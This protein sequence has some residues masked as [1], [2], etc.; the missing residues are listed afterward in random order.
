VRDDVVLIH[1]P[2]VFDFRERRVRYG[3]ISDV[4]PSS[5][6]FEMYPVGFLTMAAYLRRHGFRVRI[7]NL[8]LLMMR[9]RRFRPEKLLRKLKP[10]LFGI[11]LHWLPHAHGATELAALLKRLHPEIPIVFGGIS[12]S[13]FHEELIRDSAADFVLRGSVTEPTLLAL[14]R[15]VESGRAFE[16][17]PGLT[18][19]SEGRTRVNPP[20]TVP[21]S[22]DEFTFN[23]GSMI[24][25]V[26]S[27]LDFWTSIPFHSYWR[28]PI[29]A[30]FTVRGCRRNCV[31]CGA[32]SSSF[33]RFMPGQ[34]PLYRSPEAIAS[35]V[36][37]LAEIARAPIFLVGDIRDGG[38]SYASEVLD[39]LA[40]A[41]VESD[42]LR[43]L[44]SAIGGVSAAH[45]TIGS[46]VGRRAF[47]GEPRPRRPRP[48]R[49]GPVYE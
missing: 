8:A 47:P 21:Q 11:D 31:S 35:M 10:K 28:H 29:T 6:V 20:S 30:V 41:S 46:T 32:S 16:T 3:P 19:K 9:S 42:H 45:R 40:Q 14:L 26:V 43:V 4:I 13:Y 18:W 1:A 7:V 44:R 25:S 23:L 24:R 49:Q 36:H 37:E 22:L 48:P 39:A 17:I 2:S 12:A 34:H 38:E 15:Q 33:R 5:S 27:H